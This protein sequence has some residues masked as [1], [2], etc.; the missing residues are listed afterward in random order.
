MGA[1]GTVPVDQEPIYDPDDASI[2][3][4]FKVQ[5][6]VSYPKHYPT[7][8]WNEMQLVLGMRGDKKE[9]E[10]REYQEMLDE[11]AFQEAMEHQ[12]MYEQIDKGR[13]RQNKEEREWEEMNDYFNPRN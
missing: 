9:H 1:L 2:D 10:E 13:E 5:R 8:P 7:I 12:R 11:E 4:P 6:G 3:P